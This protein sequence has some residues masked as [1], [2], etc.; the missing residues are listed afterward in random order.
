M[1]MAL[2]D[3]LFQGVLIVA[4]E[5]AEARVAELEAEIAQLRQAQA[6]ELAEGVRSLNLTIE[7]AQALIDK[8]GPV[9]LSASTISSFCTAATVSS[10][11]SYCHTQVA[12]EIDPELNRAFV[13]LHQR[14]V[15]VMGEDGVA[16]AL[17]D[18]GNNHEVFRL[19]SI[20]PS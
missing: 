3:R 1:F 9:G 16:Q 13:I 20:P 6:D 19:D 17:V 4:E 18:Q 7:K 8:D 5:S 2:S 15:E 11:S 10:A 14:A 12:E